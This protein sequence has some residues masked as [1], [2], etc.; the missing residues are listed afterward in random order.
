MAKPARQ[1]AAQHRQAPEGVQNG[2]MFT[3]E[4]HASRIEVVALRLS[5]MSGHSGTK[6]EKLWDA[7]KADQHKEK[8]YKY[9]HAYV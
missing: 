3:R 5:N 7:R 2:V 8:V 6:H 1:K 9:G 4:C